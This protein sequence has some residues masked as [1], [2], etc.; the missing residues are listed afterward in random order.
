MWERCGKRPFCALLATVCR[1]A[2]VLVRS[3]VDLRERRERLDM[4]AGPRRR[5]PGPY[6]V[7]ARSPPRVRRA[8]LTTSRSEERDGLS[9]RDDGPAVSVLRFG[10]RRCAR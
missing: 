10:R 4:T 3:D 5:A 6:P 7:A 8:S 2:G 1:V 9:L